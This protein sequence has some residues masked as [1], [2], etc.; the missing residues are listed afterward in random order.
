MNTEIQI[1]SANDLFKENE[2]LKT[3]SSASNKMGVLA[4]VFWYACNNS[5]RESLGSVLKAFLQTSKALLPEYGVWLLAGHSAWQQDTKLNRYRKLWNSLEARGITFPNSKNQI[6]VM[7]EEAGKIRFF[8]AVEITD[9]DIESVTEVLLS[10]RSAYLV[11]LNNDANMKRIIE[12]GWCGEIESDLFTL[13]EIVDNG[14][15]VNRLG[16]FDDYEKGILIVGQSK[17]VALFQSL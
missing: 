10:E 4:G 12:V 8:G 13:E 1:I 9:T 5:P 6:E 7:H 16:E 2:I 3:I 11:L 17:D 15:L 14:L